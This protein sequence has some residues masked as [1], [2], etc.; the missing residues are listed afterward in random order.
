MSA[1]NPGDTRPPR[2]RDLSGLHRRDQIALG[3][4]AWNGARSDHDRGDDGRP[5]HGCSQKKSAV[6]V[7]SPKDV[8]SLPDLFATDSHRLPISVF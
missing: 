7:L 8:N 4:G 2:H 6:P 1:R 3:R 5:F